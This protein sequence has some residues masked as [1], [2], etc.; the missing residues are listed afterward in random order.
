MFRTGLLLILRR[1]NNVRA[2]IGMVMLYA[3]WLL[4]AAS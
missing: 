2:A 3:D 4:A 1:I